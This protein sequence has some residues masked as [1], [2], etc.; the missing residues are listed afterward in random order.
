MPYPQGTT[1]SELD[2][3]WIPSVCLCTILAGG[4][5]IFFFFFL[6]TI[7]QPHTRLSIYSFI[8]GPKNPKVIRTNT[9]TDSTAYILQHHYEVR[10]LRSTSI[11]SCTD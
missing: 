3:Y 6:Q 5:D 10:T 8:P 11:Y 2:Y 7:V 9:C 4:K 1:R